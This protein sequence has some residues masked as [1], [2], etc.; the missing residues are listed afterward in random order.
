MGE[1]SG[2][3][4]RE[5][6]TVFGAVSNLREEG[7]LTGGGM[8]SSLSLLLENV[9]PYSEWCL[10]SNNYENSFLSLKVEDEGLN[11]K[12]DQKSFSKHPVLSATI[13]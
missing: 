9:S 10:V 6:S 2:C 7:T 5:G 12:R 4:A 3:L 1:G 8:P 11:Y 13:Y